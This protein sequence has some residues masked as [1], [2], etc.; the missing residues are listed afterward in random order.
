MVDGVPRECP[1][2]MDE[3]GCSGYSDSR[4]IRM[5]VPIDYGEPSFPGPFDWHSKRS[6]FVTYIAADGFRMKPFSDVDRV[7]AKKELQHSGYDALK[8]I[9]TSQANAFMTTTFL[10]C[11]QRSF[12]SIQSNSAVQILHMTGESC[13]SWMGLNPIT[14]TK[15]G[16]NVRLVK[17]MCS[18]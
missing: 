6:T 16:R 18:F 7:T 11:G 3:I 5:I 15:F 1:F 14:Q 9:L 2:N 8:V 12:S 17:L 13:F 10:N 4:E